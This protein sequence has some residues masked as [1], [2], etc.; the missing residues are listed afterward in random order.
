MKKLELFANQVLDECSSTN[1]LAK[2]L[3]EAGYSHGTWVSAKTQNFGRGRSGRK[4]ESIEGNLFLS[5]IVRIQERALWS[6]VPLTAAV[7]V[8]RCLRDEFQDLDI[9]IKWPNDIWIEGAKLGGILCEG[10]GSQSSSFIVIG[11]GLNC[12]DSPKNVEQL[13]VDLTS[14][15]GGLQTYADQIRSSLIS[16][17]L[18][19]IH[20]LV[21]HG[22]KREA[23]FYEKW[24]VLSQGTEVQWTSFSDS[25]IQ[26]GVVQGLGSAGELKVVKESNQIVSLFAEDIKLKSSGHSESS[27]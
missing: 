18:E 6:W 2:E 20:S 8:C 14:A 16:S 27:R 11:L 10:S 24:A 1:D 19:E 15:R 23:E 17:L 4:W 13:T 21:Q 12:V 26:S 22:P 5:L 9:R 25:S 3:A 7:A